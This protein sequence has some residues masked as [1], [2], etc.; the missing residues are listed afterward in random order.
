MPTTLTPTSSK[1]RVSLQVRMVVLPDWH[2]V[3]NF[4]PIALKLNIA[5]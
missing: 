1:K 3:D 4:V 2:C 5:L